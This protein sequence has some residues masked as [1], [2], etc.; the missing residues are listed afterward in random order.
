[1][2]RIDLMNLGT[3]AKKI[4]SRELKCVAVAT[5][6]VE[7]IEKNSSL[8]AFIYFDKKSVLDKAKRLDNDLDIG[9]NRGRLHGVPILIKDNIHVKNQPNTV[10]CP[11]LKNFIPKFDS[12][13]VEILREE[14]ALF[15]GKSNLDELFIDYNGNNKYY[16]RI[17]NPHNPD[18]ISGGSSGGIGCAIASCQ[19]PAG[20][21]SDTSNSSFLK[22]NSL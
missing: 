8:N 3:L 14:G 13:V 18:Y 20:I 16:G 11:G 5:K 7:N 10:G 2:S 19:A 12:R 4:K 6:Y 1:M 22:L 9:K 21:G 17:R 15:L